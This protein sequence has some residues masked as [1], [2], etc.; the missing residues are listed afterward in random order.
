[1]YKPRMKSEIVKAGREEPT[2]EEQ[3]FIASTGQDRHKDHS[4]YFVTR[5]SETYLPFSKPSSESIVRR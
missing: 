4:K 2:V 3:T 5:R 1:M